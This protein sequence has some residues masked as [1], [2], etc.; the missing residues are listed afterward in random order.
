MA[1]VTG[2]AQNAQDNQ[3]ATVPV[4]SGTASVFSNSN[5]VQYVGAIAMV[6]TLVTGGKVNLSASDQAAIITVI[7]LV[8]GAVTFIIHRWFTSHVHAASLTK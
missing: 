3:V 4:V 5:L 1:M 7:G 6:A 8:Q 2:T